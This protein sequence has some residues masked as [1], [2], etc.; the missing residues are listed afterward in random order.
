MTF[1]KKITKSVGVMPAK[2][3]Y[4][5]AAGIIDLIII[6]FI[7][8]VLTILLRSLSLVWDLPA[9][10][11]RLFSLEKTFC[12]YYIVA[13][14]LKR[15]HTTI[16]GKMFKIYTVRRNGNPI[17]L[18]IVL[19]RV[20]FYFLFALINIIFFTLYTEEDLNFL[21][22]LSVL[23]LTLIILNAP[24]FFT[25]EIRSLIDLLSSTKVVKGEPK[26]SA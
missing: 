24:M 22:F 19:V 5:I 14:S 21:A 26:I 1:E 12:I 9:H 25:K 7:A 20:A 15:W 10:A 11:A 18:G 4:R 2:I 16:G 17:S 3:T 13:L 6:F 23:A 8:L